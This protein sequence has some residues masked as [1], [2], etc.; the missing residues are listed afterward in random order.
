LPRKSRRLWRLSAAAFAGV[1]LAQTPTPCDV[2]GSVFGKDLLATTLLVQEAS[3]YKRIVDLTRDTRIVKLPVNGESSGTPVAMSFDDIHAGD[4]VCITQKD[5]T[6]SE[7][8][9]VPR[10]EVEQAQREFAAQW[11]AHSV[12]GNV[13]SIDLKSQRL[14]VADVSLALAGGCVFRMFPADA[15]Q[16]ADAVTI[17]AEDIKPGDLVYARGT[18]PGEATLVMKGG[19][20]AILGTLVDVRV[21]EGGVRIADLASGA[22]MFVTIP[23]THLY[24]TAATGAFSTVTIAG[25]VNLAPI[26]F[27]D[28]QKGDIVM[29]VGRVSGTDV[30]GLALVSRFGSFSM[31]PESD[32]ELSWFLK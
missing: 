18:N 10:L 22:E 25:N 16:L 12:Y 13:T 2:A 20:R 21:S 4:L 24:R 29:I 23:P 19:V 9:V 3:G 17:R 6:V 31:S 15:A 32:N 11:I 27:A 28:L 1:C 14:N 8:R 26:G 5:A 7:V 30:K